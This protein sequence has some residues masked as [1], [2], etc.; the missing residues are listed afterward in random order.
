MASC[1]RSVKSRPLQC[2]AMYSNTL[3]SST[4][5]TGES[6][7][8][9]QALLALYTGFGFLRWDKGLAGHKNDVRLFEL[10]KITTRACAIRSFIHCLTTEDHLK[11]GD[12]N[13]NPSFCF[14]LYLCSSLCP[15]HCSRRHSF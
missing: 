3:L 7:T 13:T 14:F 1:R 5:N 10:E 4:H 6:A 12:S 9:S 11:T 15:Y 2:T 8:C